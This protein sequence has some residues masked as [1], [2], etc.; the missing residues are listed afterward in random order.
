V[1]EIIARLKAIKNDSDISV[2]RDGEKLYLME[3]E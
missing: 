3:E 2:G 1:E